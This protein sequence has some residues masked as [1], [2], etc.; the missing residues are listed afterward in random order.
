[1]LAKCIFFR[2]RMMKLRTMHNKMRRSI[3]VDTEDLSEEENS[4]GDDDDE[5]D[6]EMT[7]SGSIP[8]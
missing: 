5:D 1:M 6:E 4:D 2:V 3:H 7:T 8:P